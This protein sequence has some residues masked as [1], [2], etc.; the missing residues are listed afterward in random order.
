LASV[1]IVSDASIDL[2]PRLA[3]ELGLVLAPLGYEVGGHRYVTGGQ[4][5][6][7]LYA[8]LGAGN[9][10]QVDGVSADDFEVALRKAGEYSRDIICICQSVGSSFTRVSAEVAIRRVQRDG[11]VVRL[12]SPGRSTAGLGAICIAAARAANNGKGPEEVFEF[13]EELT[14]G[15]DS[16]AIPAGLDFLE[17][18]GTL[19]MM[20]SQST[21]GRID[22]GVPLFR[23]RGRVSPAAVSDDAE[24]TEQLLIDRVAATAGGRDVVVVVTHAE[25]KDAADRL[26]ERARASLRVS[27]LHVGPMGPTIGAV[28]GPGAYGLGFCAVPD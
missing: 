21:I 24:G 25:A 15:A 2:P 9:S 27:E 20:N 28:L 16:Y 11:I 7:E 10:S 3:E 17:S 12:I 19:D 4:S 23:I 18:S 5:P 1:A 14:A 26:A 13:V 8:A 6:A 22:T